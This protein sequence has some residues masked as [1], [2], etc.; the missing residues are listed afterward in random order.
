M[1]E[2]FLK[3]AGIT[4][5]AA[6]LFQYG[7]N[8]DDSKDDDSPTLPPMSSFTINVDEF[9][10]AK[11]SLVVISN[12]QLAV[13]AVNYMNSMLA[14]YMAVPVAAYAKALEQDPVHITST[15]ED[16]WLWSYNLTVN[17]TVYTAEFTAEL[18]ADSIVMEMNISQNGGFNDFLWFTGKCDLA[19]TVGEWTIYSNPE[20]P[21]AWLHITWHR[22]ASEETFDI[23]YTN[24][25]PGHT[26]EGS[27][28]EYGTMDDTSY[29]VYYTIYDSSEDKEYR[30]EANTSTHEGRLYYNLAWLCWDSYHENTTCPE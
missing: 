22:N 5:I 28:V 19:G 6:S 10:P 13:Y 15:D 3:I 17:D 7:C 16:Y 26:Y 2:F 8:K 18:T 23:R 20:S 24:I 30:I 25:A 21:E 14:A 11:K 1:R 4:L 29:N 12:Y 9:E 27:Y